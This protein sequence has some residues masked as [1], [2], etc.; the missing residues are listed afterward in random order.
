ML[1]FH[2]AVPMADPA[3]FHAMDMGS[4]KDW[5]P[6]TH[7]DYAVFVDMLKAEAAE[8]RKR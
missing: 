4:S 8:R 3:V 1:A 7:E 6:V 5:V 2:R